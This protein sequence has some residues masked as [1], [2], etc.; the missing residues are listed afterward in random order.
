MAIPARILEDHGPP[1]G[2]VGTFPTT[3][4]QLEETINAA[5]KRLAGH[6]DAPGD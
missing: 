5:E 4:R 2:G 1:P 3:L 6:V